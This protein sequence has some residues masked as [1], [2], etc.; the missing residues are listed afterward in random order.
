M[1]FRYYSL[2][3]VLLSLSL[4]GYSQSDQP[5]RKTPRVFIGPYGGQMLSVDSRSLNKKALGLM[6]E[7]QTDYGV[8]WRS[9]L[10]AAKEE[11]TDFFFSGFPPDL[12]GLEVFQVGLEFGPSLRLSKFGNIGDWNL[13]GGMLTDYARAKWISEIQYTAS[14]NETILTSLQADFLR[15]RP[16]I[17]SN[18]NFNIKQNWEIDLSLA[19]GLTSSRERRGRIGGSDQEGAYFQREDIQSSGDYARYGL[20]V[21]YRIHSKR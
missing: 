11:S 21:L 12:Q 20:S 13:G 8:T 7:L 1:L 15:V 19:I 3:I 18:V 5:D 17:H 14:T 4:G 6:G 10:F 2:A 9:L 16:I